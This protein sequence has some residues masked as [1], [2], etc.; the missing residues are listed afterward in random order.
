MNYELLAADLLR[1][2]RGPKRSRPGF[3][4][5]LGYQSN[6]AQRWE[7]GSCAPTITTFFALCERLGIGVAPCVAAFLRR[8]P[9]WL[10][11]AAFDTPQGIALLVSELRGRARLSEIAARAG[12]NRYTISRWLKGKATPKLPEFLRV[13]DACSGRV[14]DFVATLAPPEALPSAAAKWREL[15]P[16]RELAYAHPLAHAVLRASS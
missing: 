10:A 4:R 7:T 8:E 16:S 11:A 5:F 6:I 13:L 15:G 12:S 3:S 14:L 2:L 9:P 1:H